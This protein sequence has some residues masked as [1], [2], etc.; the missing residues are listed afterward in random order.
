MRPEA[1]GGVTLQKYR[2]PALYNSRSPRSISNVLRYDER[3]AATRVASPARE[4]RLA[5]LRCDRTVLNIPCIGL[6]ESKPRVG[7]SPPRIDA[8]RRCRRASPYAPYLSKARPPASRRV[9]GE[10]RRRSCQRVRRTS[11]CAATFFNPSTGRATAQRS[12]A[13][14]GRF[15]LSSVPGRCRDSHGVV[16]H[17]ILDRRELTTTPHA[18]APSARAQAEF[19]QTHPGTSPPLRRSERVDR[20]YTPYVQRRLR[21]LDR[22]SWER[23]PRKTRW[24]SRP[25]ITFPNLV[26][27]GD[28]LPAE[29]TRMFWRQR[30]DARPPILTG[31]LVPQ[32]RR[33]SRRASTPTSPRSYAAIH[34]PSR[35]RNP[36][37]WLPTSNSPRRVARNS[38]RRAQPAGSRSPPPARV[39]LR[40]AVSDRQLDGMST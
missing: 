36:I 12:S 20:D 17:S 13:A 32:S 33:S 16:N 21:R 40:H 25:A 19:S 3:P 9:P 34:S 1:A 7:N 24:C 31:N 18:F 37:R 29:T 22:K 11:W 39:F 35:C 2:L 26:N 8:D 10:T 5:K 14:V 23:R 28:L 30:A 15:S 4:T 6:Q 27:A 38:R